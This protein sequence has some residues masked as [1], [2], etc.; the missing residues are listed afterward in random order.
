[1]EVELTQERTDAALLIGGKDLLGQPTAPDVT[2]EQSACGHVG[3]RFRARIPCTWF[4]RR[5]RC[6]TRWVRR[7]TRRRSIRVRS[8]ATHVLGRKSAARSWARMRAST[9]SVLTFAS[10]MARVLRGF[11]TTTLATTG[12]K[13][14]GDGI[15]VR[16]RLQAPPG[17][18]S[19]R[20]RPRP[21]VLR[22][23]P[24]P[25]LVT[26]HPVLH[27]RDLSER[28]GGRPSRSISPLLLLDVVVDEEP[29]GGNDRNGFAL[30]AQSGQSLGRPSTNASSQLKV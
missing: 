30:A 20:F 18:P 6:R 29:P 16:R 28:T 24:D 2:G 5:V 17:P 11:D 12:S 3:T 26:A 9:L 25:P 27:D 19:Q 22:L 10:A 4:F 14:P 13:Q 21:E 7:C 1:M 23:D 15:A 8:S